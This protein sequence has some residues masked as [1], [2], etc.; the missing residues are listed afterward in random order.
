MHKTSIK[1]VKGKAT[2][3]KTEVEDKFGRWNDKYRTK[4][5]YYVIHEGKKHH[6]YYLKPYYPKY[7]EKDWEAVTEGILS[8]TSF[9]KRR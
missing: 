1:T 3:V 8:Y 5:G 2:F 4:D 9:R 6:V 7:T